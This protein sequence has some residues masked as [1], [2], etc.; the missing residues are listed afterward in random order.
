MG[1]DADVT[2]FLY[3]LDG[4]GGEDGLGDGFAQTGLALCADLLSDGAESG[5][6]V[7]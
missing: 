2:N 1:D 4:F 3:L 7:N 6:V 5:E